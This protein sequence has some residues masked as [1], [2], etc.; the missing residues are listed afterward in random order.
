MHAKEFVTS[1]QGKIH[2]HYLLG[3]GTY[4]GQISSFFTVCKKS[5]SGFKRGK[6]S[7]MRFKTGAKI[8][9]SKKKI[10]G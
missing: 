8:Y 5:R 9:L 1:N 6:K 2:T 3:R 10:G 7:T 4:D